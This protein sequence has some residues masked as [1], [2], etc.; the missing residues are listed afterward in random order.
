[1]IAHV[2]GVPI[3][4]FLLPLLVGG[5]ALYS[6]IGAVISRRRRTR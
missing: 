3:E 6:G 2:A 5:G 4:E 1:M